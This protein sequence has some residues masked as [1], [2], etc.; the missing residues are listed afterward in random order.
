MQIRKLVATAAVL[1]AFALGCATPALAQ[2]KLT[3][4]FG[5]LGNAEFPGTIGMQLM[6][7]K[8]NAAAKGEIEMQVFPNSQLG[9]EKEMAEGNRGVPPW[10]SSSRAFPMSATGDRTTSATISTRFCLAACAPC[11]AA[12]RIVPTWRRSVG[13]NGPFCV[14]S[15][16]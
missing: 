16:A 9:G 7:D 12:A 3:C 15:W 2:A 8:V 4:R 1:A 13:P 6:V 14:N 5:V 11:C 10:K